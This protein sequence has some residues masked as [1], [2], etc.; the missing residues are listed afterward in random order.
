MPRGGVRSTARNFPRVGDERAIV[1]G[2]F[3]LDLIDERLFRGAKPLPLGAKAFAVLSHLARNGGRLIKKDELLDAVWPD[4]HVTEGVLKVAVREIRRAL[5]DDVEKPRYVETVH[6]RGYRFVATVAEAVPASAEPRAAQPAAP[7]TGPAAVVGRDAELESLEE[8][9]RRAAA[10]ERQI[11]F[12]TG[13]AGIGKTTL[14]DCFL[15]RVRATAGARA[16]RGLCLDTYGAG[17]P[18]LAVLEAVARLGAEKEVVQLLADRAPS[19][20][21]QIP[22]LVSEKQRAELALR[23]A[24]RERMLREMAEAIEA[25]TAERPLVLVLEDLHWSDPSTVDL[26]GFLAR[27]PEPARF[28]LVGT[29]RPADAIF[30]EHPIRGLHQDLATQDSFAE[31]ALDFLTVAEVGELLGRRFSDDAIARTMAPLLHART[32]GSPLFVTILASELVRRGAIHRD[33]ERWRLVGDLAAQVVDVPEGL[34]QMIE[35][36]LDRLDDDD[37]R[38]LEAAS[39][40]GME[41]AT[42]SIA[43]ALESDL[44]GLEER[45]SRLARETGL[46]RPAAQRRLPDGSRETVHRF[47]HALYASVFSSRVPSARRARLVRRIAE[48]EESALGVEAADHAARLAALFESAEEIPRALA[49]RRLAAETAERRFAPAEAE[50][51]LERGLALLESLPAGAERDAEELLLQSRLGPVRMTTRGYAAAE[52]ERAFARALEL[53]EARGASEAPFP[54]LWGLWAFYVVRAELDRALGLADRCLALA[55]KS[56]D[57]GQRLEAHHALWVTHFYLG[58]FVEAEKHLDTFEPLYDADRDRGHALVYG[59]DPRM[60]GLAYRAL[61]EWGNGKPEAALESSRAAVEHARAVGH[62]MSLGFALV[63]AAW[64]HLAR[65][66]ADACRTEAEAVM[67]LAAEHGF[68]HWLASGLHFHGWALV[69]SGEV[70]AGIGEIEQG[71]ALWTAIGA[72]MGRSGYLTTLAEAKAKAG[73]R[74]EALALID[75]ALAFL[76]TTGERYHEPEIHRLRGELL[77][78]GDAGEEE[79]E[80]CFQRAIDAAKRQRVL[81]TEVRAATSL[82]RHARAPAKKKRARETLRALVERWGPER[83]DPPEIRE[84]RELLAG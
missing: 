8:R 47:A 30:E 40:G 55:K 38:V 5:D 83:G 21:A 62:P 18:Y 26:I 3:R 59:Q 68:P 24:S 20:L 74:E 10:G 7:P 44:E 56:R 71:M 42:P 4:V 39:L 72:G 49:Y 57:Q 84:A 31:I 1:F 6:R 11:V 52:V 76:E 17:E 61:V 75:Q 22:W 27:R 70:E 32:D 23:G 78:D 58:D 48:R 81:S 73:N 65:G 34:R 9:L 33:G 82:A 36:Q 12:V 46:L 28:L 67:G 64:L 15:A 35:R 80:R 41:F 79:V 66:D 19:W 60:A 54:V 50:A 14:V 45:C 53:T 77:S 13:E 2:P 51:H 29:Y 37:R 16:A 63:F 69:E 25:L 43:A